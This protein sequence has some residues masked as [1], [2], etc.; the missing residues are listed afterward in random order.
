[1]LNS[2]DHGN[3]SLFLLKDYVSVKPK[4]QWNTYLNIQN[5]DIRGVL[6]EHRVNVLKQ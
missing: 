4:E 5:K 3:L 1:M 6:S 2:Y